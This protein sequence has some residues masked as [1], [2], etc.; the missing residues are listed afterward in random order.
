MHVTCVV[1]ARPNFMK[2]APILDAARGLAGV[3]TCLVHTGQHYDARMSALFFDEL[4][5]P[6]PDVE[7][8]VGS[9]THAVQTARVMQEFDRALDQRPTDLVVVVGDVNSTLACALVAVKRGIAVAHVEAGLRSFDRRMPEEINR[10]LTDQ[11]SDLLFTTERAA[12]SHLAREGIP[13]ERVHFVGN[14]MIDTL[15][16]HRERARRSDV[17]ARLGLARRE[18]AV[19][20]LHRP[21]NVDEPDAA[22]NTVRALSEVAGRLHTVV[23]LHPRT[24]ARLAHHGLLDRLLQHESMTLLE[25]L[26]YYEFLALMDQ[27]GVVFTD[28]GG[29]QEET[30]AL[31]VPCLTFREN[32]ERPITITHGTNRLVGVDPA[33]VAAAMDAVVR[34]GSESAAIPELWDGHASERIWRVLLERAGETTPA[35][36]LMAEPA[37]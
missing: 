4:G 7:L 26:G 25:P 1:G 27:A 10:V 11:V 14:V 21:S 36:S 30:T 8:G 12:A 16:R 35:A 17:L 32:T 28:S 23:P 6:R 5:L 3:E 2:V 18:Y 19:A 33:R 15:Y 29:I 22:A 9:A 20:T 34:G 31:G 24:R 37:Q 13:A